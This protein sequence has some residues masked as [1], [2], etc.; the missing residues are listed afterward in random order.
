MKLCVFFPGIGYHCDKPL[1]YYGGRLA[2]SMG[3]E[4]IALKYSDFPRGAKGNDD[5]IHTAADHALM[6]SEQQLAD[7]DF[8]AYEKVVLVGKS[9]GTAACTAFREKHS[10]KAEC[11]LLTPLA[12]TFEHDT[13]DS[14]AF[15]GTAD[16][17]ADTAEIRRLCKERGIPLYEYENADHS[18]ETGD[19]TKNIETVKD[20]TEKLRQVLE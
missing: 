16:P 6:Q 11:V 13:V 8:S 7:I 19:V 14:V 15:H 20:V 3:Y 17:W 10:V 4:T 5:K 2:K 9:I 1:L 12:V 18:L